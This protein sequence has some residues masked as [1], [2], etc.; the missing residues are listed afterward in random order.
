MIRHAPSTTSI[1]ALA[2][3]ALLGLTACASPGSPEASQPAP[4]GGQTLAQLTTTLDEIDG[5]TFSN[6]GGSEPNIKGNT[7]FTFQVR[8]DPDYRLVD[9]AGLVEYLAEAAWSVNDNPMPNTDVQISYF[10]AP[11]D[12][13]NLAE[14]ARTAG[15]IAPGKPFADTSNGSSLVAIPV[16]DY[17]ADQG[18]PENA[19]RLGPW[20][21]AV[22]TP[23]DDLVIPRTE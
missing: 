13:I 10:G 5:L 20:P 8:L 19:E 23:P 15:W 6:V 11:K 3:A 17:A 7:G 2:L 9:P 21:G 18:V 1:S 22:P 4:T 14:E 12:G 16:S